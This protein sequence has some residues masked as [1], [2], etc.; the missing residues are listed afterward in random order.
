[1]FI[2]FIYYRIVNHQI[3]CVLPSIH[4]CIVVS[5]LGLGR[6]PR[7]P[8]WQMQERGTAGHSLDSFRNP[9]TTSDPDFQL[10]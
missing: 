10:S 4:V 3:S 9:A 8:G 7:C 6:P 5:D 1:M 2:I